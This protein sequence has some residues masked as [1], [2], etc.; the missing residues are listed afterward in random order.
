MRSCTRRSRMATSSVC[1]SA[2]LSPAFD[3]QSMLSTVATQ[4]AR[5]SRETGGGAL[6][7]RGGG[8]AGEDQQGGETGDAKRHVGWRRCGGA[9]GDVRTTRGASPAP[10]SYY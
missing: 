4:T 1:C 9:E 10:R 8:G 3:G 5:S 7:A 2:A 6:C